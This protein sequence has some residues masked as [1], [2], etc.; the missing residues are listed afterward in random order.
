MPDEDI[1]LLRYWEGKLET[2][3]EEIAH[4]NAATVEVTPDNAADMEKMLEDA[5]N[6]GRKNGTLFNAVS[7]ILEQFE[8]TDAASL[9]LVQDSTNVT[10]NDLSSHIKMPKFDIPKF[11]GE[12]T[13][14][15]PFSELFIASVDKNPNIPAIQ[16]FNYLKTSLT[17]EALH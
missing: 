15:I 4:L 7:S 13:K 5:E 17:D 10:S 1:D 12:N 11:N 2:K 3:V 6:L 14:G 16:K 9:A 8:E